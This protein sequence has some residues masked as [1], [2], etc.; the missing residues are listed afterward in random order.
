[1]PESLTAPTPRPVLQSPVTWGGI[2]IW[3]DRLSDALD[4]CNDDKAAIADLYLRRM[5][6]LSNAAKTGQ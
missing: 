4:T 5:Q 3:S 6:R 2:A 1:M